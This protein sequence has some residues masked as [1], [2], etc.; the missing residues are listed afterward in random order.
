M[1][2][3]SKPTIWSWTSEHHANLKPAIYRKRTS[4]PEPKPTVSAPTSCK[5]SQ[6]TTQNRLDSSQKHG[7][8]SSECLECHPEAENGATTSIRQPRLTSP[9]THCQ[10]ISRSKSDVRLYFVQQRLIDTCRDNSTSSSQFHLSY[11]VYTQPRGP[12]KTARNPG[13]QNG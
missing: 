6:L 10:G 3:S 2:I 4:H 13:S 9:C 8:A 11:T 7:D 12:V 5:V 1:D